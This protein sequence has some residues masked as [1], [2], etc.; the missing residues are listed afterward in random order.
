[1]GV[2]VYVCVCEY[3]C[4]QKCVF[5]GTFERARTCVFFM[6]GIACVCVFVNKIH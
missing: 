2:H 1:M 5:V 6:L 4:V 3:A